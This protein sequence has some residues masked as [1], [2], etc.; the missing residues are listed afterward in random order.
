[1]FV[2]QEWGV[3]KYGYLRLIFMIAWIS[4]L[5]SGL[6]DIQ[7]QS[8]DSLKQMLRT[9]IPVGIIYKNTGQLEKAIENYSGAYEVYKSISHYDNMATCA[10]NIANV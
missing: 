4:C 6:S 5:P 2:K 1:M 7:A 3:I 9:D 10:L 8:L